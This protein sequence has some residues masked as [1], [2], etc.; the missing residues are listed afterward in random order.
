MECGLNVGLICLTGDLG[1]TTMSVIGRG[2][3]KV[4]FSAI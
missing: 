4:V 3:T 2:Q 1:E